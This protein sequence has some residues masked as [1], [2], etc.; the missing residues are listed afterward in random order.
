MFDERLIGC[1]VN[2]SP[3]RQIRHQTQIK[4]F[5]NDW[6]LVL[7]FS[8]YLDHNLKWPAVKWKRWQFNQSL[9][10][11]VTKTQQEEQQKRTEKCLA[12]ITQILRGYRH[13]LEY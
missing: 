11:L 10:T 6:F 13:P 12:W 3:H 1:L 2:V 9:L 7:V 4:C 5:E 8:N